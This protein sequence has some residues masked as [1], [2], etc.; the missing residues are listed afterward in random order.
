MA[1]AA[2]GRVRWRVMMECSGRL[3]AA[4]T[5]GWVL[6]CSGGRGAAEGGGKV[7][8]RAEGGVQQRA[9]ARCGEGGG[10]VEGEG[11]VQWRGGC[12]VGRGPR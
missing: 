12:G 2:E 5:D 9:G 4:R 7:R 1:G 10:A 3:T 8:Q 6:G 11:E